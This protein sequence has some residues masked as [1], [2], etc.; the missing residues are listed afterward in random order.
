MS[1]RKHTAHTGVNLTP[2]L[3]IV[4]ALAVLLPAAACNQ[5]TGQPAQ[6]SDTPASTP[7]TRVTA[8]PIPAGSTRPTAAPTTARPTLLPT[9]S[10]DIQPSALRG[11]RVQFW[12]PWTG[13]AGQTLESRLAEFNRSN[14]WGITASVTGYQGLG[15]LDDAVKAASLAENPPNLLAAYTYQA[16]G[17]DVGGTTLVDL[18]A[19]TS[20]PQW[21]LPET[22]VAD[23]YPA[24]WD[25]DL[26]TLPGA[27]ADLVKRLGVPLHRLA[28]VIFYNRT[29]AEE[30]GFSS[31]PVSSAGLH[32]QACAAARAN[33]TDL[34]RDNNNTGGWLLTAQPGVLTGWVQ[35]FGGQIN[36]ADGR[37]YQLDTPQAQQALEFIK[38][39]QDDGCAWNPEMSDPAAAFASRQALFYAASLADLPAL[40]QAF[41]QA[42]SPDE[43][44]AIPFPSE[45]GTPVIV[46]YGPSLSIV[47]TTSVQDLAAWELLKW[48]VTPA[49]QAQW[50]QAGGYL[51]V[52]ATARTSLSTSAAA[53]EPW[54]SALNL[55]PYASPEPT[56]TSWP[57]VRRL[58]GDALQAFYDPLQKAE[59]LPDFLSD[60]DALVADVHNQ[61]R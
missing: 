25:A 57:V 17:W 8:S 34:D 47:H 28:V 35:A 46:A 37:G 14:S 24:F 26:V 56:Y 49:S 59:G 30:L 1:Y 32:I 52:R 5:P 7:S 42:G 6:V 31:P 21:G 11:V 50:A 44:I 48:L 29:W 16:M 40:T 10:L 15:A 58:L 18:Q 43:W 41:T 12:H 22:D 13:E 51:P 45:A 54:V 53:G 60:L 20:D 36:R 38:G 55:L 27:Q 23:F 3:Q 9:S 19:Y 33:N 61:A 4:L 2:F 39:L